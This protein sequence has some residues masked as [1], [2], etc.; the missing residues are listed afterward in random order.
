MLDNLVEHVGSATLQ[1]RI[2]EGW[3]MERRPGDFGMEIVG[4]LL[5]PILVEA[6]K[7]FWAS[8]VK[9]LSEKAGSDLADLSLTS[10]KNLAAR[11]WSGK[12]TS[13]NLGEL[14]ALVR[15]IAQ[16]RLPREQID[17]LVAKL[18]NAKVAEQFTNGRR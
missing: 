12:E 15:D 6:A 11:I 14:E 3:T 7:Q 1:E 8:Y 13:A 4:A 5:V 18:R 2:A 10:M 17:G 9:R 16:G